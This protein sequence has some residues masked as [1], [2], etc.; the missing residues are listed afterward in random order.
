MQDKGLTHCCMR[1][2]FTT[3][4]CFLVCV[5]HASAQS[6]VATATGRPF[7]L[8]LGYSYVHRFDGPYDQ[9]GLN[10]A[11]ANISI[12]V[13]SHLS[14]RADLGYARAANVLGT[15]RH[16]DVLTYLVGPVFYPTARRH[17]NTYIQA[18]MGGARVTGPIFL[19]GG[20]FLDGGWANKFS[21][22]AGGGAEFW[23]TDSM[24]VRTG[25]EYLRT[26]YYDAAL[27]I[28]GQNNIRTTATVAYYFGRRSRR[29]R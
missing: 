5:A 29:G 11:D 24:T 4:L 6:P 12:S 19:N 13:H 28:R 27:S 7:D 2:I 1:T 21:W 3:L 10:G 16:S 20:G 22:A 15:G 23:V 18:L 9:V 26:A 14:I 25:V 17:F 8:G